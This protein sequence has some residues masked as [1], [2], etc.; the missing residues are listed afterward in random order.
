MGKEL[1]K[2]IDIRNQFVTLLNDFPKENL[3]IKYF[4]KWSLK[5]I[6]KHLIGWE[7]YMVKVVE[8]CKSNSQIKFYGKVN[9]FNQN[10]LNIMKDWTWDM[11]NNEYLR[12]SKKLIEYFNFLPEDIINKKIWVKRKYTPLIL[13]RVQII[14]Y[15]KDHL[16]KIIRIMDSFKHF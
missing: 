5:D 10:S 11:L 4:K 2:Y 6:L 9:E 8:S 15:K 7:N 13:L 3:D 12:A 1:S 14:H 16:P